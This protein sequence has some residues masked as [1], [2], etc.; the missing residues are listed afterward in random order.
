M[1]F[2][3]SIVSLLVVLFGSLTVLG[4]ERQKTPYKAYIASDGV[5]VRSGPGKNYYP[6]MKLPLGAEVEVYR[7][8]PGG[9]YAIKPP[10]ESFTWV[11]ARYV[12]VD[13]DGLGT[14]KGEQ[15]AARVG[16]TFSDIRDVIQVRM[17]EGEV[18]EILG[19][20]Q[21]TG[22]SEAGKWYRVA[23]PSGE[24]RWVFGRLV[25]ANYMTSGVRS[26]AGTTSPLLI[27]PRPPARPQKD[28]QEKLEEPAHLSDL[29]NDSDV[30]GDTDFAVI[31][32]GVLDLSEE[33][34]GGSEVEF[35]PKPRQ[36]D[37]VA[38]DG[39]GADLS[40]PRPIRP[41]RAATYEEPAK[42]AAEASTRPKK[43]TGYVSPRLPE[44]NEPEEDERARPRAVD[45]PLLPFGESLDRLEFELA[46]ML[47]EE[48]T[49]WSFTE[50][51]IQAQ[52][53]LERARTALERGKVRLLLKKIAQSDDVKQRYAKFVDTEVQL[54]RREERLDGLR[55]EPKWNDSEGTT[56]SARPTAKRYD[57]YGRLGRII[58]SEPNAPRYA[59]VDDKNNNKVNCYVT[60]AP[61]VNLDYYV[62]RRIGVVGASN[63]MPNRQ[64][65]QVMAKHVTPLETASRR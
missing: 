20:K 16:S 14:I 61:G 62:G 7:H 4:A 11:A 22:T 44:L 49:V 12:E 9:W 1:R 46:R 17:Y 19:E 42:A 15:V 26:T 38:A 39:T 41:E 3:I 40:E 5:Y 51:D 33:R 13:E 10:E 35:E 65:R 64:A 23:P 2:G 8:D 58:T 25:D 50:L 21:F 43:S 30:A 37:W 47:S 31:E 56:A 18:V 55:D 54:D 34:I 52:S 36:A 24:F 59:L 53:L 60:P 45:R 48:P 27:P 32:P 29:D 6:T 57:G 28:V 63:Y